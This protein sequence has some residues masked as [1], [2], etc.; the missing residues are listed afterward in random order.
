MLAFF[1]LMLSFSA[2]DTRQYDRVS[3]SM[4]AAFADDLGGVFD[5]VSLARLGVPLAGPPARQGTEPARLGAPAEGLERMVREPEKTYARITA[6]L[7]Q[8]IDS[9]MIRVELTDRAVVLRFDD[10][11]F[12]SQG[13]ERVTP[14]F[15]TVIARISSLLGDTEGAIVVQGHTDDVPISTPRFRSNWELSTAR[16]VSVV[17]ELLNNPAIERNRVVVEGH[18]DATPLVPNDSP[19]HRAQNRR[20][21][22]HI[23]T[24][25][26]DP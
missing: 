18:A 26:T 5:R 19:R 11:A 2:T 12:F 15:R 7:W 6:S 3:H 9:G 22:I 24:A 14:S 17:H 8:E 10:M 20:V 13:S 1:V 4:A 21:E 25:S 23:S 16:A